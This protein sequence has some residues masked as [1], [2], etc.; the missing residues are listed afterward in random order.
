MVKQARYVNCDDAKVAEYTALIVPRIVALYE[1][2]QRG[3]PDDFS[4][5]FA[6]AGFQFLAQ[7]TMQTLGDDGYNARLRYLSFA[8]HRW[9][10]AI[11]LRAC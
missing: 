4:T 2:L 7:L 3:N 10:R 11:E 5:A 1:E 9:D 6:N 8:K